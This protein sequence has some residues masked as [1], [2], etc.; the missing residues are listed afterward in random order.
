MTTFIVR[1]HDRVTGS[2]PSGHRLAVKDLID[3]AGVPTTAGCPVVADRAEPVAADAACLAGARAAGAAIVGKTNLHELAFGGTGVNPHFGTPVNPLDPARMPGGSSS[4]SAVAVA[5]G[6]AGVAFGT[7]TAGSVRT[8]SAFCGTVGLKTTAGRIP[9]DGVWPLAPS[10]D[11]V[12][13]M[14]RDV[15]AVATGMAL[16]EPGFAVAG[17]PARMVGRLRLHGIDPRVDAAI[18]ATLAVAEVEVVDLVLPA[19]HDAARAGTTV[20]YAEAWR[21][22]GAVYEAGADRLGADVRERLERGRAIPAAHL[23]AARAH[24]RA[25]RAETGRVLGGVELIA[26]P[27]VGVLP[28]LLDAPP[29]DTRTTN[30]PANLAGLPSLALPVPVPATAPGRRP[31]ESHLPASVQLVGPARSESLLLATGALIEAAARTLV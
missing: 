28:P 25:W 30:V 1:T 17:E 19:W 10:L 29:P 27:T 21:S 26:L 6:E 3:V 16:L 8:P 13:P 2:E 11:T 14:G 12:G 4:G 15:A 20:L 23:A 18:D 22:D 24:G 31:G 7:D 9:L 5:A